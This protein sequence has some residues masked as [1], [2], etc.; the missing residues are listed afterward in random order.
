MSSLTIEGIIL[1]RINFGEADRVLTVLTKNLGKISDIARGVRKITSR[2]AGNVELLNIVKLGLF[3]G[4]GYTLTEAESIETFPKIKSNLAVSTAAFHILELANRFLPEN[5]PNFRSY[6]LIIETFKKIEEN[7]RQIFVRAFEVK[8]LTLL[9]FANFHVYTPRVS[10]QKV[11]TQLHLGGVPKK[12][13]EILLKLEVA[14][15]SEIS[16]LVIPKDESV[17]LEQVLRYYLESVLE[18]KLKSASVMRGL[19]NGSK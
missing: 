9:G 6:D 2:R 4:K 10:T 19:K 1:K 18:G 3:K 7:P 12:L 5:Q 8:F 15:W 11:S 17:A 16:E 13:R 14:T